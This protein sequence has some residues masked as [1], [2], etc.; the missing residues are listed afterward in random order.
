MGII[1]VLWGCFDGC[2]VDFWGIIGDVVVVFWECFGGI[3][4]FW[5]G[6]C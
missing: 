3:E 2:C 5:V 1:E 6:V 4:Y